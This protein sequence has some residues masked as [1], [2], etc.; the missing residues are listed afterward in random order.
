MC[1]LNSALPQWYINHIYNIT[2]DINN[3]TIHNSIYIPQ[4]ACAHSFLVLHNIVTCVHL[5]IH[6]QSQVKNR[7]ITTRMPCAT[8]LQT[9]SP[10]PP[11]PPQFLTSGNCYSVLHFYHFVSSKL[12]CKQNHIACNPLLL[13]FFFFSLSMI[14]MRF[15]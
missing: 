12:L 7:S 2:M 8:L 5:Y 1:I 14:P 10:T 3:D 15:T 11:I 4:C 6:Y 13:A 9:H